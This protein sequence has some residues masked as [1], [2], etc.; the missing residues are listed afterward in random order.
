MPSILFILGHTIPR[1]QPYSAPTRPMQE[2]TPTNQETPFLAKETLVK[3]ATPMTPDMVPLILDT[4]ASISITPCRS[5]FIMPLHPVQHV[6]I[7]GITSGLKGE[8]IGD[9]SYTFMND[10]GSDQTL[11]LH[12]CLYGPQ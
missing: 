1:T 4:G 3:L 8:G 2:Y 12:N 5:D 7:K 11:V 6:T 9:V 10:S